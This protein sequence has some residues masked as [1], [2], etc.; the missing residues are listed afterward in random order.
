MQ[1]TASRFDAPA[2]QAWLG[3]EYRRDWKRFVTEGCRYRILDV[4]CAQHSAQMLMWFAPQARCVF[5]RHLA[6]VST[7]VL[8]GELRVWEQT[9]Q[10]EVLKLKPAG[11]FSVGGKDEIHIEGGGAQGAVI[12]Y[13]MQADA[14]VVY[15]ILNPDLQ[16]RRSISVEDF[17][18]DWR[19][20][21]PLDHKPA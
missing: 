8:Q 20:S 3:E 10:G 21:W 6:T 11:S 4:N 15:Q 19:E 17:E 16:L 5:H 13:H 14:P 1:A 7:F 2:A 18:R 12:Y 9:P